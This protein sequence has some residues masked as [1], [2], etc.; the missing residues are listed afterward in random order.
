[1]FA[2]IRYMQVRME[3]IKHT[4][5]LKSSLPGKTETMPPPPQNSSTP[6]DYRSNVS[7][8]MPQIA[9]ATIGWTMS[10]FNLQQ[11]TN[12]QTIKQK[13]THAVQIDSP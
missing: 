10:S 13:P 2:E 1:M 6:D 7:D 11:N 5:F 8:W 4:Q 3:A 12:K 9:D